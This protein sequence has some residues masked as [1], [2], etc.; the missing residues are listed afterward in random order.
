MT[1]IEQPFE[2]LI[3]PRRDMFNIAET[4]YRVYFDA[5]NYKLIEAVSALDALR[6][7]GI[8]K[9]Y[10]IERH[11]PMGDN[12]IQFSHQPI[13]APVI[14]ENNATPNDVHEYVEIEPEKI[15]K[16]SPEEHI[17]S[18]P[19]PTPEAAPEPNETQ[20]TPAES[21]GLSNDEVEK[22]LNGQ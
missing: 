16:I 18:A 2:E 14:L 5:K 11:N 6:S 10:K 9:A 4:R 17:F 1:Q 20:A 13:I 7:S 3:I 21:S 22:L 8:S 15:E 12:I 19:E